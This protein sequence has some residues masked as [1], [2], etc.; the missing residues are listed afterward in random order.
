MMLDAATF[1]TDEE[2]TGWRT[3]KGGKH[4]KIDGEGRIVAGNIGQ[5]KGAKVNSSKG[6]KPGGRTKPLHTKGQGKP[7]PSG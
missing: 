4:Y 3:T 6:G 7:K 2:D 1:A 5:K